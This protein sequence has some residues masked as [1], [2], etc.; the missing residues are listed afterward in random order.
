MARDSKIDLNTAEI[1][2]LVAL[3]GI[4]DPLARA[5]IDQRDEQGGFDRWEDVQ[6]ISGIGPV[7]LERLRAVAVIGR[8]DDARP[9]QLSVVPGDIDSDGF[10]EALLAEDPAEEDV[11][12]T[13]AR[14][15]LEAALAYDVAAVSA[16]DARLRDALQSFRD[17]HLRHVEE[18]NRI[19]KDRGG[20][21]P[22]G[23]ANRTD[24]LLPAVARLTLPFGSDA[25][26][27]ALLVNE[28][29]TNGVYEMVLEF[30]WDNEV[31]ELLEK[32]LSDEQ[33]HLIWLSDRA[34]VLAEE[35][36]ADSDASPQA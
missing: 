16:Q 28:Q 3:D 6:S 7:L 17:D 24:L 14:M 35:S 4:N 31:S 11:L 33:R 22:D 19:L 12:T 10:D 9:R 32:N 2:D 25:A 27:V 30:E 15:D 18:L 26:L 1:E 23:M 29:M 8:A 5:I 13:L 21:P 36:E 34:Q 20:G